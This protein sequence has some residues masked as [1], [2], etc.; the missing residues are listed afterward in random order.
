MGCGRGIG[1]IGDGRS[2]RGCSWRSDRGWGGD[3]GQALEEFLAGGFEGGADG[4]GEEGAGVIVAAKFNEDAGA[5]EADDLKFDRGGG[6]FG[7]G[8]PGGEGVI[9]VGVEDIVVGFGGAPGVAGF[10]G[11]ELG[12]ACEL[13]EKGAVEQLLSVD[14]VVEVVVV[15]DV[16]EFTELVVVEGFVGGEGDGVD[17]EAEGG[18]IL[19]GFGEVVAELLVDDGDFGVY[20]VGVLE[21]DVGL[22][23]FTDV[24]EEFAVENEGVEVVA[25]VVEVFEVGVIDG[26]GAAVAFV[27]GPGVGFAGE[28]L[29]EVVVL[30]GEGGEAL[31]FGGVGVVGGAGVGVGGEEVGFVVDAGGDG[32]LAGLKFGANGT[33]GRGELED[34]GVVVGGRLRIADG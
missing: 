23:V 33:D 7:E 31:V 11:V 2:T 27:V 5:V 6:A 18:G 32:F 3:G 1:G 14:F 13:G 9:P 4:L 26:L 15:I 20:A 28:G 24:T 21:D 16:E 19:A 8:V 30:L 17:E 22:L 29:E 12:G 10:G 25:E 34:E